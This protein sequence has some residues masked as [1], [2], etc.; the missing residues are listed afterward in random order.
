MER[1]Y[2]QN[3][4]SEHLLLQALAYDRAGD[5]YNAVKLY[6]RVIRMAPD[7]S[8][9]FSFLSLIYKQRNEWQTSLHYSQKAIENNPFDEMAWEN[10]GIAATALK[11]WELA[12][13]AWHQLGFKL[14]KYKD[15]PALNPSPII[16]R[17]NPK[18]KP[19]VVLAQ[20]IDPVRARIQSVPQPSSMHGFQ[21]LILF[22]NKPNGFHYIE[23]K[24]FPVFDELEM[25]RPS[26]YFTF[27]VELLTDSMHDVLT[28]EKLCHE[29]NLGFDNWSNAYRMT[30]N[31]KLK[32]I[33]SYDISAFPIED[34]DQFLVAMGAERDSDVLEIL[35]AWAVI[36]LK[37]YGKIQRF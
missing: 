5:V 26:L 14:S 11:R 27:A 24:K 22:D 37:E 29:A 21:D 8:V 32:N 34:N 12:K 33:E 25:I 10:L 23:N 6:K 36:S 20:R 18:T 3:D 15:T 7:W 16:V 31:T 17:L 28:L 4:A 2:G 1:Y 30:Q 9:P 35:K 19:E 13:N